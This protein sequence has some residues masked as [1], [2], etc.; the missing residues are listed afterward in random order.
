M[1]PAEKGG[2]P[3]L[4]ITTIGADPDMR[5]AGAIA[6]DDDEDDIAGESFLNELGLR[7]IKQSR[8]IH[9][10]E[11]P[12]DEVMVLILRTVDKAN[13]KVIYHRNTSTVDFFH[14]AKL[15]HDATKNVPDWLGFRSPVKGQRELV[16]RRPPM[17][18]RFRS[19]L[20]PACSL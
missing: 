15:W 17:Y 6:G 11:Y 19:R 20:Y 9:E 5:L 4:M 7:V 8:G 1:I 2:G 12:Q 16:W 18:H 10:H 14:A 3:D 13:R